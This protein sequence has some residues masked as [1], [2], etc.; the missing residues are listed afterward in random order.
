MIQRKRLRQKIYRALLHSL[1]SDFHGSESRHHDY[2]QM[3]VLRMQLFEKSQT[4]HA[5]QLQIGEHQVRVSSLF[6]PFLGR[7]DGL[8]GVSVRRQLQA[9]H[10]AV[11][12]FVFD[13]QNGLFF[14]HGFCLE[15][16]CSYSATGRYTRN[17]LP[18]PGALSTV[19]CPPCSSTILET[20]ARPMPTPSALVVKNG[21]NILSRWFASIPE[22]RSMTAISAF[23]PSAVAARRVLTVTTA[24]GGLACAAFDNKFVTTC[25]ISSPAIRTGGTSGE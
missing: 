15:T 12:F 19:I 9:D 1:Y 7:A 11:F 5:R 10:A 22:P 13:H 24:P 18:S 17:T 20:M 3:G 21:L 6:Q 14:A 16:R 8:H 25:S 2:R 4:V 23:C